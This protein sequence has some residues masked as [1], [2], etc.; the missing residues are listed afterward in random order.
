[1][2]KKARQKCATSGSS[3]QKEMRQ[4][5]LELQAAAAAKTKKKRSSRALG[6]YFYTYQLGWWN[7]LVY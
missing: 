7:D 6:K 4:K 1:M 5:I 3:K 2:V